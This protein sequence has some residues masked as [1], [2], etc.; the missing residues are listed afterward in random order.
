[1]C[2]TC[3][4]TAAAPRWQC[5]REVKAYQHVKYFH[6]HPGLYQTCSFLRRPLLKKLVTE[7]LEKET[8]LLVPLSPLS[9]TPGGPLLLSLAGHVGTVTSVTAVV[10]RRSSRMKEPSD[11]SIHSLVVISASTDRS[12]RSWDVK[13]SG[14]LKTFDGHTDK[15]LSVALSNGGEYVAS[16]SQDKTVRLAD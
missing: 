6:Y 14:V 5:D 4:Q 9:I 15:V 1:M 11:G 10:A 7:A 3:E 2:A 8:P 16:G 13:T 12:L